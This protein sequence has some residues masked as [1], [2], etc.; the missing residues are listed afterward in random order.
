MRPGTHPPI[1][2]VLNKRNKGGKFSYGLYESLLYENCH[3]LLRV[4]IPPPSH[5]Q[6]SKTKVENLAMALVNKPIMR[7][8]PFY[9]PGAPPPTK[10]S[11]NE[12]NQGGNLVKRQ[13]DEGC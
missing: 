9:A 7:K 3:F 1:K 10:P 5:L 4:A 13:A 2:A 8:L 6:T 12:Q 11:L